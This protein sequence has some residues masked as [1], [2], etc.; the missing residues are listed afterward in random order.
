V[1]TDA[2]DTARPITDESSKASA[3]SSIVAALVSISSA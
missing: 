1:L 2:E 3:L